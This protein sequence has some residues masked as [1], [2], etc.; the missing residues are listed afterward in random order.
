MAKKQ[1]YYTIDSNTG[2]FIKHACEKLPEGKYGYVDGKFT[3]KGTANWPNNYGGNDSLDYVMNPVNG[4]RYTS[5]GKYYQAVRD[6]GCVVIG[7]EKPKPRKQEVRGDFNVRKELT[8]ATRQ[9]L[10]KGRSK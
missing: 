8:E 3:R 7:N 10:S 1:V 9:V 2:E 6:A 4:Q 5:K